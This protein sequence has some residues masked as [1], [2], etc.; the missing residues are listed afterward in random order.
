M[1]PVSS[2]SNVSKKKKIYFKRYKFTC[3]RSPFTFYCCFIIP[4]CQLFF[5]FS[6]ANDYDSFRFYF[7]VAKKYESYQIL[8]PLK[9]T[10]I[11]DIRLRGYR[12]GLEKR[13]SQP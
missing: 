8:P 7:H 12:T 11:R 2:E 13:A 9:N 1:L 3:T 5:F 10:L 4:I 6:S